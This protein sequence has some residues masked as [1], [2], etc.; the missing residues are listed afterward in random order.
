MVTTKLELQVSKIFNV[1]DCS[2]VFGSELITKI[3]VESDHD[4]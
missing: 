1:T 2:T 3:G 4:L